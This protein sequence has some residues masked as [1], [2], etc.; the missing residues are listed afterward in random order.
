MTVSRKGDGFFMG[1]S[2][3]GI[4]IAA[5]FHTKLHIMPTINQ[6]ITPF[7]WFDK[8]AE[9]AVNFYTAIFK[10]SKVNAITH[11]SEAAANASGQP[12][13]SVMTI[14]FELDGQEFVAINGGPV[15][16]LTEA[17]SFVVNCKDQEEIDYYWQQLTNGGEESVCGWLKDKFGLSW[18]VT[19]IILPELLKDPVKG[20]RAMQAVVKMKKI[21][22]SK[23]ENG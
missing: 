14:S 5:S 13:G 1:K 8:N 4:D 21:E 7:L 11:Y 12:K 2:H 3:R 17:V 10:N 20:E 23:L 19:P 15:F 6:R 22:I 16:K 9:E 18:Q